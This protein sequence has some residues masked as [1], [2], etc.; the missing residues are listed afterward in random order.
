M[1][2]DFYICPQYFICKRK[3]CPH[4]ILHKSIK[5][6]RRGFE[7]ECHNL[8][9][10]GICDYDPEQKVIRCVQSDAKLIAEYEKSFN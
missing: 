6:M 8:V 5:F 9:S 3:G 2:D 1:N 4:S 7:H 10:R